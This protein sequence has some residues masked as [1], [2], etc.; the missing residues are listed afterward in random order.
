VPSHRRG[1][2]PCFCSSSASS[3]A[4]WREAAQIQI[5]IGLRFRTLRGIDE[6]VKPPA[7]VE[8]RGVTPLHSLLPS[9]RDCAARRSLPC[10]DARDKPRTGDLGQVSQRPTKFSSAPIPR[11][12]SRIPALDARRRSLT[13]AQSCDQM[14]DDWPWEAE[15]RM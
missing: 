14:S 7:S 3:R 11:S 2:G 12:S 4:G 9:I 10:L 13:V 5:W 15:C 8:S 6:Q 1:A